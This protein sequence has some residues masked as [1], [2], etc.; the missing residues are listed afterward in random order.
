MKS[1]FFEKFNKIEKPSDNL[2]KTWR[3]FREE[4]EVES[5]H[6]PKS[7]IKVGRDFTRET[8]LA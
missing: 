4:M 2:S 7:E 5:V 8:M 3:G 1:W 6:T